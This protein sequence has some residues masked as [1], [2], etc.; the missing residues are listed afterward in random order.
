MLNFQGHGLIDLFYDIICPLITL[1]FLWKF[2]WLLPKIGKDSSVW[3]VIFVGIIFL[4]L[5]NNYYAFFEAKHLLIESQAL[6]SPT[7]LSF[8]VYGS[9]SVLGLYSTVYSTVVLVGHYAKNTTQVLIGLL[10]LCFA[11]GFGVALGLLD[12]YS[13][14][15]VT[16]PALTFHTVMAVFNT[17]E[18]LGIALTSSLFLCC[19]TLPAFKSFHPS[20]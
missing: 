4:F 2:R 11:N 9:I 10:I 1:I 20:L 16:N 17:P 19:V 8:L 18:Y 5:P 13:W 7:A 6:Q 15:A 12:L 3:D 14:Q